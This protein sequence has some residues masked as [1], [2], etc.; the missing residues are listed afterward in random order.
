MGAAFGIIYDREDPP[1]ASYTIGKLRFD[2]EEP[3]FYDTVWGRGPDPDLL[4]DMRKGMAMSIGSGSPCCIV[5]VN[6]VAAGELK[7]CQLERW[8]WSWRCPRAIGRSIYERGARTK[9]C[10]TAGRTAARNAVGI[11][12]GSCD[13]PIWLRRKEEDISCG[14]NGER[15]RIHHGWGSEEEDTSLFTTQKGDYIHIFS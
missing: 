6:P 3:H 12:R 13:R 1:S 2:R 8:S 10:N 11:G 14:F 9:S 5:A 15:K 7:G 4:S